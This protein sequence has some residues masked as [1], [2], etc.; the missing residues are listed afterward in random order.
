MSLSRWT[1]HRY[2]YLRPWTSEVTGKDSHSHRSVD[3]H[4]QGEEGGKEEGPRDC[5][6]PG[7]AVVRTVRALV[8]TAHLAD[9]EDVERRGVESPDEEPFRP[10]RFNNDSLSCTSEVSHGVV[11]PDRV[12]EAARFGRNVIKVPDSLARLLH[13]GVLHLRN[14]PVFDD[15]VGVRLKH[16]VA[17]WDIDDQHGH[18]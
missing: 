17:G 8:G 12:L 10:Q 15:L 6:Q 4:Q 14:N 5:R 9:T 11:T 1:S 7:R 3:E 13:V 18:A 2:L 16:D